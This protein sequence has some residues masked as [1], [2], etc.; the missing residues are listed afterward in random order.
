MEYWWSTVLCSDTDDAI[1]STVPSMGRDPRRFDERSLKQVSTPGVAQ[2]EA[3][4]TTCGTLDNR[5]CRR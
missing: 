5:K 4:L 1:Q 3:T 2:I